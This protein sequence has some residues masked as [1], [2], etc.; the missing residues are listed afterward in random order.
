M[1]CVCVGVATWQGRADATEGGASCVLCGRCLGL[2]AAQAEGI[3]RPRRQ[4]ASR[5]PSMRKRPRLPIG[6]W[7][8]WTAR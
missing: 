5:P 4:Q 7:R 1:P 6:A 2:L 8:E 3:T